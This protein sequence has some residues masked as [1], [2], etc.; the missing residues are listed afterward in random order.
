MIICISMRSKAVANWKTFTEF[1]SGA[2]CCV[3]LDFAFSIYEYNDS[4]Q[5]GTAVYT[6]SGERVLARESMEFFT[7]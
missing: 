4:G 7:K 6:S 2:V 3:N 1:Y 5:K